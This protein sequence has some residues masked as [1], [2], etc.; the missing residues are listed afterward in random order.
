[1]ATAVPRRGEESTI[2]SSPKVSSGPNFR[3]APFGSRISSSPSITPY[4]SAPVSPASKTTPPD[5]NLHIQPLPAPWKLRRH[6]PA[7]D[8]GSRALAPIGTIDG[9]SAGSTDRRWDFR[10]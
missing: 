5:G 1:M 2:E 9:R 6:Y 4:V 8:T 3:T 7:A 10:L